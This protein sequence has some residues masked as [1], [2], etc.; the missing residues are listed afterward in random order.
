MVLSQKSRAEMFSYFSSTPLG[1]EVT[2]E[3]IASFP[4]Y[5]LD[6]LVTKDFLRAELSERFA[7]VRSDTATLRND[8][9]E[10]FGAVR[11]GTATLRNDMTEQFGAVR[12]EI[13]TLRTDMTEQFGAVRGEIATLRTDMTEQFGAVRGEIATLRTDMTEQT[14]KLLLWMVATMVTL[15]GIMSGLIVTLH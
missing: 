14:Q 10:Q 4:D 3:M 13:A 9:T 2:S 15:F 1:E 8:T 7:A 11:G 6:D 5:N 12:G